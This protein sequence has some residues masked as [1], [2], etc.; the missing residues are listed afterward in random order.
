MTMYLERFKEEVPSIDEV[1][2]LLA[3]LSILSD[4]DYD[5]ATIIE[6]LSMNHY[7]CADLHVFMVLS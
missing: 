5:F 4:L 1:K 7:G 2:P 6:C 3:D